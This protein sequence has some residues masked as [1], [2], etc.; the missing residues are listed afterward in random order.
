MYELLRRLNPTVFNEYLEVIEQSTYN[1]GRE[2]NVN[3]GLESLACLK[4]KDLEHHKNLRKQQILKLQ[5]KNRI[6][7]HTF[8]D[9]AKYT[10][11]I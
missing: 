1:L 5:L 4:P 9:Q 3:S 8:G 10:S 11:R 7:V 2:E 6:Q